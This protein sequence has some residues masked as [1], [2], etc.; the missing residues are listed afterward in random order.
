MG[1]LEAICDSFDMSNV[2]TDFRL[3]LTS[4]PSDQ[5]C[6]LADL[7]RHSR[8]RGRYAFRLLSGN[9]FERLQSSE[10]PSGSNTTR[11]N[12][13]ANNFTVLEI[14]ITVEYCRYFRKEEKN[15]PS[16]ETKIKSSNLACFIWAWLVRVA[17]Y[18]WNIFYKTAFKLFYNFFSINEIH[19]NVH[20]TDY[21]NYGSD[22]AKTISRTKI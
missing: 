2:N 19:A 11:S 12:V 1:S 10:I 9:D 13:N 18:V 15:M 8:T 6:R 3:W 4:Y 22:Y 14:E 7:Q 17:A 16:D 20:R 5:V 21:A